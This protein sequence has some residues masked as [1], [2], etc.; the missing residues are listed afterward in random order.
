MRIGYLELFRPPPPTLS[1]LD[2]V[3]QDQG[4]AGARLGV[5][6]NQTTGKFLG[7]SYELITDVVPEDGDILA[8]AKAM[9]S[10][11]PFVVVNAD[12]AVM[13]SIADLPAAADAVL[14]NAGSRENALRSDGCRGNLLHTLPS[15]RMLAD[16]LAQFALKK[17]WKEWA[18]V[19][20][21][22]AGDRDFA[23]SLEVAARKFALT[24][25]ARKDWNFDVDMR[26]SAAQ[27]F[28]LFV[29]DF[30]DHDL[31]LVADE[32]NDFARYVLYNTWL[33]RPV[34]GGAGMTAA[35]WNPAVEQHGAAQLQSRFRDAA[36]RHM[37]PIDYAAWVAV[38]AVGEAATRTQSDDPAAVRAFLLS[39]AFRLAAFKGRPVSFRNWNGQMR[40]PI[41]LAHPDAVV[42]L[43]PLDG[44]LHHHNE[45]D[46]LGLDAPESACT[47][48]GDQ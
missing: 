27:E 41:P 10:K 48:F 1:N 35:A 26:R 20:G 3:P 15:R 21:P 11:T 43:A 29:Q 22:Q 37:R 17:N 5:S 13:Q 9:L 4:L 33:P 28:P 42:A 44:F 2:G 30:P 31:L 19:V 34:A 24:I 46:T 39:D 6:D 38:R 45:L 16:A 7:H 36:N 8:A 40:Q 18:L 25:R 47:A 32:Y 14:F 23:A 12:A